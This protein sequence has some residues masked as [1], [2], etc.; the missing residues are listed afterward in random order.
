MILPMDPLLATLWALL[1]TAVCIF[2]GL[3]VVNVVAAT[4]PIHGFIIAVIQ[5]LVIAMSVIWCIRRLKAILL[6]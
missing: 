2:L 1:L 4:M 6:P 5:L 3:W